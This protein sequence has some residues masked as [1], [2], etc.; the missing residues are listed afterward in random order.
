M[1]ASSADLVFVLGAGDLLRFL[2]AAALLAAAVPLC[3]NLEDVSLFTM[4]LLASLSCVSSLGAILGAAW[5][6]DAEDSDHALR[7]AGIAVTTVTGC[8]AALH[9]VMTLAAS[10]GWRGWAFFSF[11]ASVLVWVNA[12]W[13]KLS[14][15][16]SPT[17]KAPDLEQW[18]P[19]AETPKKEKKAHAPLPPGVEAVLVESGSFRVDS[20]RMLSKLAEYQLPHAPQ[21]LIPWLRLAV[22]S[23]AARLT[24]DTGG[25]ALTF[26]FDGRALESRFLKDPW[27][28]LTAEE[29]DAQAGRHRHLAYGLLALLRLEPRAVRGWS[30]EGAGR[31]ALSII[32]APGQPPLAEEDPGGPRTALKVRLS[33][34]SGALRVQEAASLARLSWGLADAAFVVDGAAVRSPEAG[35]DGSH[36]FEKDGFRVVASVPVAKNPGNPGT[37]RFYHLGA[38][39]CE[40]AE[41]WQVKGGVVASVSHPEFELNASQDDVVHGELRERG[42][43]LAAR[44]GKE[45][46]DG[47]PRSREFAYSKPALACALGSSAASF[48]VFTAAAALRPEL[49]LFSGTLFGLATAG[50]LGLCLKW[51]AGRL[52][53]ERNPFRG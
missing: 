3:P 1:R 46:K 38:L 22:A 32:D 8:L 9:L 10:E 49:A 6:F 27:S 13:R 30:G 47:G 28:A 48:A 43:E 24:L 7:R 40:N 45:V 42:V 2:A 26:S 11:A 18:V 33:G 31:T 23:G 17:R 12:P 4:F 50:A 39:V 41:S 5:F 35:R 29:D 16:L 20:A 21:F 52:R 14:R 37:L 53:G 25:T 19:R 51:A 44:A 34:A 15:L 36:G